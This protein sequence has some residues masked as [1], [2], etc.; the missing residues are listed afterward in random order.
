M[1][2]TTKPSQQDVERA[3]WYIWRMARYR[4]PLFLITV[5]TIMP[6][7][8]FPLLPGLVVRQVF[9][10]ASANRQIG[11]DLWT[12]M[13][14]LIGIAIAHMVTMTAAG[15]LENT[16]QLVVA[17]LLRQNMLERIM[18]RP[19]ASALPPGSSPGEAVSR[20]RNDV[21][22]VVG[23]LTWTFDPVGQILVSIAALVI[24]SSIN[25]LI[26]V[27][28]F[29]PLVLVLVIVNLSNNRIRKFRKA[30]QEAIGEVTGLLGE[31][32]GSVTA[33]K[34]ANAEQ[35][36][37][38]HLRIVNEARRKAS[39]SDVLFSQLLSS[40]SFNAANLSTG[41]LLL[42]AAQA[43]HTGR[44][45][46][47]DFALFVSYVGWLAFVT[48]MVGNYV[49]QYR[50][51]GVSLRRLIDLLQVDTSPGSTEPHILVKHSP[52]HLRGALPEIPFPAHSAADRLDQLDVRGLSYHYPGTQRG[53]EDVNMVL[54]R[55]TLTV[56]TGQIGC[57]KT[58]V[59]R[60]LLGLLPAQA[61]E[62]YW[63]GRLIDQP[64]TFFV[65][66]RSAYTAQAPRLFSESLKDNILMG[67]TEEQVD[68][69]RAIRTAVFEQDVTA[70]DHGLATLVGPRGVKLS[71]G[72]LQRAAAVRMFV[73]DTELVV[74]DDLSS[75]L[76]VE[77]ER[78][79][80]ER[81]LG[82][83]T[84]DGRR[85]TDDSSSVLRPSSTLLVVSHR[86]AALRRADNIIV[87]KDGRVEAQGKLDDLLVSCDEM[88]RLWHGEI[89]E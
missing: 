25:P 4:L 22:V 40:V 20:F 3:W 43:M 66:P 24:L 61:G 53:I 30:N 73:R 75:A 34:V 81:V 36:V 77:T 63:N 87:L 15:T 49:T 86:K 39:L 59:L 71:G 9:D 64:A 67:S 51:V 79:L 37:V 42:I 35:N 85:R 62:I 47:G 76:D 55:G 21:Q 23:F 28:V 33:V 19:G 41:V 16:T 18:Q 80:W 72:Q 56:I 46:V 58:T 82:G 2:D 29:V 74:F 1:T 52:T 54:P 27:A 83:A 78:T 68:L 69:P 45:T 6:F 70:L 50:Q 10:A 84:D 32:F 11:A 48:G 60:A 57:G 14:L 13:A 8:L 88:R 65:P 5:I 7:Y 31:I 38:E 12:A 89:R 26:T 44:F 17:T